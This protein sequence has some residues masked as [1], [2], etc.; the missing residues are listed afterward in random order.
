VTKLDT[1]I[2]EFAA[3]DVTHK[4]IDDTLENHKKRIGKFKGV[5]GAKSS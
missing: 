3:H 1:V 4:R 2:K 5:V